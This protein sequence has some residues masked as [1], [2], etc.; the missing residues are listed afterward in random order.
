MFNAILLDKNEDGSTRAQLTQLDD[1]Q[2]PADGDVTVR[3]DYSTIN[4]KDGLAITGKSPVV[5]K[6]P[7]VPGID[8]AGEV[9]ESSHPDWKPGDAFVLNGWGV[10][11]VHPG[12]LAQRARLKGDWLIRLPQNMSARSAMAIGTAGYTA[13]LCVMAL[14]DHGIRPDSGEILVTGASGGVGSVA[15]ALLAAAGYRVVASTGKLGE[16]DYLQALGAAEV[17]DRAQLSA[18]GKPLQKERWAG[19]VDSVGSHTLVNALAQT[20]YGGAVAA[21]GLAQ[22]LDLPGSV[23]PFILR[24][25]SLLGIDSVMA[26]R[27]RRER[28][29]QRLAAELKPA[30]LDRITSEIPL[31]E[32]LDRAPDIIAGKIRG[33]LVVNVNR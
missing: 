8:G 27:A 19:V 15:V 13:M 33:R 14:Q 30:L 11:E 17:I 18:P 7:M 4:F 10:G 9:I 3:V 25:V 22:G 21:C 23:A 1:A 26:P 20:R 28:A 12:C 24:G 16:S 29:W 6:W 5:R 31:A 2:L 32:A